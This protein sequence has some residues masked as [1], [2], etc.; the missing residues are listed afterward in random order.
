MN[1]HLFVYGSL[2]SS[3]RHPMGERLRGEGRLLGEAWVQGRLY[4]VSWYPGMV[5]SEEPDARVFG[6][7]Y[8]LAD[9]QRSFAWLDAYEGIVPGNP[10]CDEYTRAERC[11]R[12]AS[13]Q[14]LTSWLYL[15]RGSVAGL[16]MVADGRWVQTLPSKPR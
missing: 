3:A 10:D 15:Y 16:P 13:G 5:D 8:L 14:A 4:R 2:M 11:V 9:A 7:V 12:L 6:E 1:P